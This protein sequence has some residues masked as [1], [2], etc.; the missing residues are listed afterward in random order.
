MERKDDGGGGGDNSSQI[1]TT[2]TN[3]CS[4]GRWANACVQKVLILSHLRNAAL[5]LCPA[6]RVGALSDDVRL[7]S[8]C[9]VHRA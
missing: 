8:V 3:V 7:T 5:L 6:P 4:T 1:I 2:A 9:C